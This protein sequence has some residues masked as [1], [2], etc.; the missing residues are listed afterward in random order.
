MICTSIQNRSFEEIFTLLE[1]GALEMAEIR[2]DRCPL[3]DEEIATL[4]SY[5]DVPLVATCRI[6][7]VASGSLD[8]L[9]RSRRDAESLC[10]ARLSLAVEAGAKYVDL[11]IEASAPVGKR[12]RRACQQY[13]TVMIRSYHDFTG[14]PPAET[15]RSAYDKCRMFGAGLV[16]IVTTAH[17]P[18]DALRALEMYEYAAGDPLIAFAMGEE[19]HDSRLRCL[20]LGAPFTYAALTD[21][22]LT[23]PGQWAQKDI[24]MALYGK[25]GSGK[26]FDGRNLVM[27]AS[28]SFAQRAI[29]AAALSEGTS[30]LSGY[31]PCDDSE[32]AISA[33]E[34]LGAIVRREEGPEGQ[35]TLEI[36]GTGASYGS[37]SIREIHTGE[38]GL[39]TR[40][41]IPVL[42][43]VSDGPVRVRG[44]KTLLKRPLAGAHDI[45][46]SFGVRL[47]PEAE[48]SQGMRPTDCMVPLTVAGPLIPGRAEISGRDGSQLVSGLLSA[49]PLCAGDSD[50]YVT[51]PRSIPYMFITVDVLKK[52]GVE[53]TS[54]VEG[55]DEFLTTGD[56]NLATGVTF[57]IKGRQSYQAA[58]FH[59]EGD[60]SGAAAFLVAGA[61]FGG[62]EI[63]GLDT[64]SLQAD[65]SVMDVLMDAGA[66]MSQEEGPDGKGSTGTVRLRRAPLNCFDT[67]LNN[68][69]DLFPV[70]AVLACFCP[71]KSHI[72]GVGR[73][74]HKETD[75]SAA[76]VGMLTKM[77]VEVS[78]DDDVMTITGMS[79]SQ[80]I[81]TGNLLK[82]GD[83]ASFG[84]H[85]MVMALKVASLGA[86][87]PV[88][89]DDETCVSKSFPGFIELFERQIV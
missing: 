82:G 85:R 60:W 31:S 75:R 43:A 9:P 74:R 66:A 11:E 8:G 49:L 81:A 36:T 50:V 71:G 72:A 41:L 42:S 5:S 3:S 18:S 34:E 33:A 4:F 12:L 56:W 32:A 65:L 83:F 69:P 39:L 47:I 64:S 24:S 54:E 1:D 29:L 10:E 73:L 63:D 55:D 77:G 48:P 79:L 14:T 51:D 22:E 57:H 58:D 89:I 88:R 19:G 61:V 84:D 15:L 30:R 53:I 86:D 45:M 78:V 37:S 76:I 7:E 38:S 26:R 13:G 27:P 2:L 44:E 23:A 52:F 40:M 70:V 25:E 59:I 46:A 16:K 35:C 20:S 28:K 68:C 6:S 67:D 80:R 62:V 21:S 17:S 87:S